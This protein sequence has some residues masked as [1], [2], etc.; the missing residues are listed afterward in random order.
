MTKP[1]NAADNY[2]LLSQGLMRQI[3]E[4]VRA[5]QN[6]TML[7]II[8]STGR[9]V[10]MKQLEEM[11]SGPNPKQKP[12]YREID[13]DIA[14]DYLSQ[15]KKDFEGFQSFRETL[16]GPANKAPETKAPEKPKADEHVHNGPYPIVDLVMR[17]EKVYKEVKKSLGTDS[18]WGKFRD[19]ISGGKYSQK[20]LED[21]VG[22]V[23]GDQ[24]KSYG[25]KDAESVI[26]Y[27]KSEKLSGP[28]KT[29]DEIR[30]SAKNLISA[31]NK[32]FGD[33]KSWASKRQVDG[34]RPSGSTKVRDVNS[35]GSDNTQDKGR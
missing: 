6:E 32:T 7:K 20:K 24:S 2:T 16:K 34:Q 14:I 27:L 13:I 4:K 12:K 3:L 33:L 31:G 8:D 5:S 17:D 22:K 30:N 11:I 18:I 25:R 23:V 29:L 26:G 19:G 35:L 10:F 28:I 21:A 9:D 1:T 15:G